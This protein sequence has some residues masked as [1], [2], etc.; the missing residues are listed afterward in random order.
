[1][2]V[3]SSGIVDGVIAD[4]YGKRGELYDFGMPALSLPLSIVDVPVGTQSF[5]VFCEDKDAYPVSGGFSWVHWV[6]ANFT[7]PEIPEDASRTDQGIVQ[8][9]NSWMSAQGGNVDPDLC[10]CYGGMAP[11][12]APHIY[13]FH[14]YALDCVLD[15][16]P[17]FMLG[18]M[19]RAME[20][21]VLAEA[22][23]KGSYAA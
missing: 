4:K 14:V 10:S 5:A 3:T 12:D 16:E 21:H 2:K 15:L 18:E 6:A 9:P 7:S 8:G 19:F 17:G 1:M 23:L 11:P 13:E 20:G 22:V